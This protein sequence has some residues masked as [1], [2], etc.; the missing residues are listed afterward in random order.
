M[1]HTL[2]KLLL[3]RLWLFTYLIPCVNDNSTRRLYIWV[4]SVLSV[5]LVQAKDNGTLTILTY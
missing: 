4:V 2:M 5:H 3:I 1:L